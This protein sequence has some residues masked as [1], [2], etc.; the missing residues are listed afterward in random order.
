MPRPVGRRW[1][2]RLRTGSQSFQRTQSRSETEAVPRF[3]PENQMWW[4]CGEH[5]WLKLRM[6]QGSEASQTLE[7]W[8]LY[9]EEGKLWNWLDWHEPSQV[10]NAAN[11]RDKNSKAL[12]HSLSDSS[13]SLFLRKL[14]SVI[15]QTSQNQKSIL[16]INT[17]WL[18]TEGRWLRHPLGSSILCTEVSDAVHGTHQAEHSKIMRASAG[19]S[20]NKLFLCCIFRP[21]KS[22]FS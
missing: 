15:F 2:H 6:P 19:G 18:S 21:G 17:F 1:G 11:S 20:G 12:K 7:N 8:K 22:Q 4:G 10:N 13:F 14:F 9:K 3:T 16:R 5:V